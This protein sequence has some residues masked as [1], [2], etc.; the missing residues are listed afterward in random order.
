MRVQ[1]FKTKR[2]PA[3]EAENFCLRILVVAAVLFFFSGCIGGKRPNVIDQYTIEYSSPAFNGFSRIDTSIKVGMFSVNQAFNSPAMVYAPAPFQQDAY[4]YNRWIVNP[5]DMITDYLLRD[6]RN[7]GLFAAVFSYSGTEE[8]PFLLQG[9]VEKFLEVDE[10]DSSKAELT[11][12][13]TLIDT[14]RKGLTNR[15]VF[16]KNY[17]AA[18]PPEKKSARGFAESMSGAMQNISKQLISDIYHSI[19]ESAVRK[20]LPQNLQR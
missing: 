7:S 15:I 12:N 3:S 10:K 6:L 8:A 1:L 4:N 13:A 17:S 18:G 5:G 2:E 11:L 19:K 16:Q 9:N 20:P 14:S